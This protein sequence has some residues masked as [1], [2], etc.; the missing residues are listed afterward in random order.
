MTDTTPSTPPDPPIRR[1][2]KPEDSGCRLDMFLAG[3]PE[4]GVRSV[5][6]EMVRAGR[7]QVDGRSCKPGTSLEPGQEV[8]FRLLEVSAEEPAPEIP[9]PEFDVLYEDPFILVIN[10]PAGIPA[11]PPENRR[12]WTGP[13][14]AHMA[15]RH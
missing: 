10:K 5:A 9:W 11:H 1:R 15:L 3:Q 6:K 7:V 12:A 4:V 13:D 2:I 14:I 8:S